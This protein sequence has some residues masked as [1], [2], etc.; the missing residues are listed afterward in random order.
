[1]GLLRL[2]FSIFVVLYHCGQFSAFKFMQGPEAVQSFYLISGFYMALI[3]NEKYNK[4]G[5]YKLFLSNRF[6]RLFPAY[7]IVLALIILFSVSALVFS[8]GN[9]WGMLHMYKNNVANLN[10]VSMFYLVCTN[11]FMVGQDVAMY[12]GLNS[13]GILF[14]TKNY[15]LTADPKVYEFLLVPQAWTIGIE[16]MFYLIA[17][18]IVRRSVLFIIFL[19][20]IAASLKIILARSGLTN[21]PW[22]YRF[23]PAE[24]LFFLQG[25]LAYKLL[26]VFRTFQ[27]PP[28]LLLAVFAIT[29]VVVLSYMYLHYYIRMYFYFIGLAISLPLIFLYTKDMKWDRIIGDFSYPIYISHL[30]F[31]ALLYRMG[32]AA[33]ISLL[34]VLCSL[35]F[36]ILL[37]KYILKRIDNYRQSRLLIQA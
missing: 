24:M 29:V 13:S 31:K 19:L 15:A 35:I 5:S 21:D 12:L 17:P 16:I 30:F 2:L 1:M 34:V 3:L 26:L 10:P 6:L 14:F 11:I 36:S 8:K 28:N 18:F 4:P 22:S 25:V 7:W 32:F 37:N 9:D 33:N 20:I 23:F 27:L